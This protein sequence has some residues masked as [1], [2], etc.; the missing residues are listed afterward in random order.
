MDG[1]CVLHQPPN[2]SAVKKIDKSEYEKGYGEGIEESN[3]DLK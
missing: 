3:L 1:Y 2:A